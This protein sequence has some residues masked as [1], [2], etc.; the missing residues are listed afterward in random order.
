MLETK[1]RR[2]A[3][4]LA[5]LMLALCCLGAA[6]P[7]EIDVQTHTLPNGLTVLLSR[8]TRLPVVAVE[9]R[10][11]V[12]SGHERQ[13]RSGFAHLFEH[14]MFQG[15][16]NYDDEYFKP[17]EKVGGSVNGTTNT[18]RTNYFERVPK[19]YLE[20]A[21]WM[22]SDRME[23]LLDALTQAKLDNQRDVVKNERRQRYENTPYGMVWKYF[24]NNLYP[25]GHPYQ[26]TTIGSH[27]DLTAATLDDVKGFFRAHYVPKNALVTIVGD[28]EPKATLAMVEKYFG[29]LDAGE[30]TPMPKAALPKAKKEHIVEKDDVKLPRI[31]LAWHTP[32]L[33]EQGDAEMDVLASVLSDGKTSRLY[34][35][36]VYDKKVAKDVSAF[37]VSRAL[38]SMFVVQATVAPGGSIDELA[39]ELEGALKTALASPPTEDEM[40]RSVNGWR[41]S[42]YGRVEGVLSRAQLLSTY[43]HLTGKAD[44]VAEDLARYTKLKAGDV[45]KAAKD[46]IELDAP[47]RVDIIP[48]GK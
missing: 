48:E 3:L 4:T 2:W 13:G 27:E 28:F 31:Y 41:K 40:L 35:P 12:G 24:H 25:Q 7:P 26:H 8:D 30:R 43:F 34:K 23:H 14:L 11:M 37:Q 19:E 5:T 9:V 45:A 39:T 17:F 46:Y 42:F 32:A 18:D 22:E 15:S 44:Y 38:G 33:Y 10:Y 6:P 29:H 16:K 21:L 1:V 36:L 47:L 20:L